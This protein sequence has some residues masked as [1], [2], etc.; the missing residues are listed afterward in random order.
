MLRLE[1]A[2]TKEL[3][4][5]PLTVTCFKNVGCYEFCEKIQRVKHHPMLTRLFISGLHENQVKLAGVT[6]TLSTVVIS[7]ATGIPNVGEKW[8]K[9]G[10]LKKQDFEFLLKPRHQNQTKRFFPFSHLLDRY[11]PMMKIIMKYFS[12]EG[13][14]SRLYSY[15]IRIL[16]NF[17]RVRMLNIPY[18]LFQSIEKIAYI[19]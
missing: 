18:Y 9:K 8:F 5:S 12:C 3:L 6:F 4:A 10:R 2:N 14:F 19:S 11:A 17:T 1:P 7:D 16:M 15:H 13:I